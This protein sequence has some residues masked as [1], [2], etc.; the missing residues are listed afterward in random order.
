MSHEPHP[1]TNAGSDTGSGTATPR[2]EGGSLCTCFK[3]RRATRRVTQIYDRHLQPTGLRITQYGLLAR[4]RGGP[5]HMTELAE[6]MGMDRTTLT[7][8]LRPLE[9]LGY[10]AVD[11]GEDRRTRSV[12]LTDTGRAA[13][14]AALPYWREAQAAVRAA[15]GA[16]L[17]DD[18]HGLLDRAFAGLPAE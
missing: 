10:V 16:P 15:L 1:E 9:R 7:R 18:L 13:A 17:T 2:G 3:L 4:L 6:R 12:L 5:L 8:N 14:S 11:P